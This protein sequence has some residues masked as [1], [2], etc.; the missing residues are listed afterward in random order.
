MFT[1][2]YL[3]MGSVSADFRNA[4]QATQSTGGRETIAAIALGLF[5]TCN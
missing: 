1:R 3:R 2:M 5:V 4:R